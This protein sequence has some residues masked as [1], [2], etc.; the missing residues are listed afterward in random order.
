MKNTTMK[1]KKSKFKSKLDKSL[2]DYACYELGN[3]YEVYKIYNMKNEFVIWTLVDIKM[4]QDIAS[5]E[6]KEE[7]LKLITTIGDF[8]KCQKKKN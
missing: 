8:A 3:N 4:N 7:F 6:N 1:W 5:S 2:T